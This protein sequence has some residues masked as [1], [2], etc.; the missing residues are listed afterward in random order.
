MGVAP[1][2]RHLLGGGRQLL[3]QGMF[4]LVSHTISISH[5]PFGYQIGY[6]SQMKPT[7]RYLAGILGLAI[8]YVVAAKLGLSL[9][10]TV[11]QITTVW[12]PSGLALVALVVYGYRMWPGVFIGALVA[13]LLTA[14]PLG[15]ATGIAVGNTL[16]AVVGALL[17]R[18]VV[19][20]QPALNRARP[21]NETR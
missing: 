1:T 3:G 20:L 7:L 19:R 8:L 17:V 18:R 11:K 12:P 6:N 2:N 9:A 15:V 13:N 21:G 14:E 5:W 16:E 4:G 10:L